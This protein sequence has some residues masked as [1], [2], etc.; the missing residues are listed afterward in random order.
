MKWFDS[1]AKKRFMALLLSVTVACTSI[2][3]V[4]AADS[5][6]KDDVMTATS[7]CVQG[8]KE[9]VQ[10][11]PENPEKQI[12]SAQSVSME[13][14]EVGADATK[15]T[16]SG[17][18]NWWGTASQATTKVGEKA[19]IISERKSTIIDSEIK[20]GYE[21]QT[22]P[23]FK[24]DTEWKNFNMGTQD[25]MF[26]IKLPATGKGSTLRIASIEMDG[27]SKYPSPS[28]MKYQYLELTGKE[29]IDGTISNDDNKQMNLPDGFEGYIRL[30]L[31][32]AKNCADYASTTI[33]LQNVAFNIGS[34]GGEYGPAVVGGAWFVSKANSCEISID[35]SEAVQMVVKGIVAQSVS[36]ETGEVGADA[37]KITKSGDDNWWGTASQATTKVGEKA[38]IISERKSTIID[39]E[40]KEGY[41]NQTAPVFKFDTEWKNFNMGTQDFMFYIKLPATGKGSTLRIASIEMDGWSK[42]PSPSG[43]KYQY[44]ELTGKEWIDGTISND[45][46]KQMNLPDGFEGYIRL[47]LNSAKNCADYA[48]TTIALQNVAFNIGSFGGEY[49][50]AVVGGAWF[51]SK[52]DNCEISIDGEEILDMTI[53]KEENPDEDTTNLEPSGIELDDCENW[54]GATK[55]TTIAVGDKIAP[56]GEAKSVVFSSLEE[57]GTHVGKSAQI[58]RISPEYEIE[59]GKED[60]MFYLELPSLQMDN[61]VVWLKDFYSK[62]TDSWGNYKNG[63]N[64]EYLEANG[65]EWVSVKSDAEGR[66][67]L[68]DGFK[69]Y[70]KI[71]SDEI[72]LWTSSTGKQMLD[73]FR[74][75]LGGYGGK[76]GDAKIGGVWIVSRSNSLYAC[77]DGGQKQPLTTYWTD[78]EAALTEYKE[79]VASLSEINL[80]VAV[81][82]DR[83]NTLYNL[84]SDEYKSKITKDELDKVNEY[85]VAIR[86]YRPQLFGVSVREQGSTPQGLKI[87]WT[88]DD[89]YLTSQG[90]EI[91]SSGAVALYEMNYDGKA[92]IDKNTQDAVILNGE[93]SPKGYYFAVLDVEDDYIDQPI[94]MR[95]Y[96]VIKNTTTNQEITI[97]C[98]EYTDSSSQSNVYMKCSLKEVAHYFRVSLFAK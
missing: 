78:N 62:S 44:L 65:T 57:E 42:Y 15:I 12:I 46:N 76:Y 98:D 80:E 89:K 63:K 72:S 68:P 4:K 28:G 66:I 22:A 13:T 40:I 31:N 20:E 39:S 2:G 86:P 8:K 18:D 51:V 69:G 92:T 79:L 74:I 33:A 1:T 6:E 50:P 77:V 36:M 19:T 87:G 24:F 25:F 14:G 3:A 9:E 16:K 93:K 85:T 70:I 34:F 90:Y 43:M 88:L 37:T 82:L 10:P 53:D 94:L 5:H 27:W 84:M 49:G 95:A 17:D 47:K 59:I 23:V 32:S 75:H 81:T 58:I 29:W 61:T 30:K 60:I 35:D 38:T 56:I 41:E 73:F 21:N 97:W 26:Y 55:R 45:D 83:L 91:L 11:E 71:H 67:E 64:A 48:S 54:W 7:V 52:A 96:V